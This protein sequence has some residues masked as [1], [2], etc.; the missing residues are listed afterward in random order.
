MLSKCWIRKK[1][2]N[3]I[4]FSDSFYFSLHFHLYYWIIHLDIENVWT[5][6]NISW[7]ISYNRGNLLKTDMGKY[8]P[9]IIYL[10][11]CLLNRMN[12]VDDVTTANFLEYLLQNVLNWCYLLKTGAHKKWLIIMRNSRQTFAYLFD[13]E[14]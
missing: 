7:Y 10:E 2:L 9:K 11:N 14:Y 4:D 3:Q 6:N 12:Q 1:N 8:F 5:D 13:F